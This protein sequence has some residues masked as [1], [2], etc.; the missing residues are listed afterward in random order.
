MSIYIT[1]GTTKGFLMKA[2][3]LEELHSMAQTLGVRRKFCKNGQYLVPQD[4]REQAI[5]LGV[6]TKKK[7]PKNKS[8]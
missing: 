4:K 6:Q 1:S 5:S 2:D 8:K 7:P 3:N